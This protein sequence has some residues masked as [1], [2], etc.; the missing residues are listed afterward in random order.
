MD[1]LGNQLTVDLQIGDI[2]V[3]KIPEENECMHQMMEWSPETMLIVKNGIDDCLSF[4]VALMHLVFFAT[5]M[6]LTLFIIW[7]WMLLNHL[8]ES[9]AP[10]DLRGFLSFWWWIFYQPFLS[11]VLVKLISKSRPAA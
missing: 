2:S 11:V 6:S 8:F 5:L 7:K 4:L 10:E 1:F 3:I 9:T